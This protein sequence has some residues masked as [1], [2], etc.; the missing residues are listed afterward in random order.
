MRRGGQFSVIFIHLSSFKLQQLVLLLEWLFWVKLVKYS[1]WLG[2]IQPESVE[3]LKELAGSS[4]MVI[5]NHPL[6]KTSSDYALLPFICVWKVCTC[7]S[8]RECYPPDPEFVAVKVFSGECWLILDSETLL[9]KLKRL[10]TI[11]GEFSN[12]FLLTLG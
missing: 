2:I 3:V 7:V 10:S 11:W 1:Q 6:Q 4:A 8:K 12:E 5:C 9:M